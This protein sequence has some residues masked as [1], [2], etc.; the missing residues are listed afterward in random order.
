[1]SGRYNI[2]DIVLTSWTLVRLISDGVN[3]QVYEA[4]HEDSGEICKSM[5]KIG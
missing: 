2:G 3:E 4:E 5:V 1:M